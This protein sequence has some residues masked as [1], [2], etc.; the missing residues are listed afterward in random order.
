[1]I[2]NVSALSA[3]AA[4]AEFAPPTAISAALAAY[5]VGGAPMGAI[6]RESLAP[7]AVLI[8]LALAMLIFAPELSALIA[9]WSAVK[10]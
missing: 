4:V 1:M 5:V 9:G 2:L 8:A 3:L 10:P 7:V 6:I